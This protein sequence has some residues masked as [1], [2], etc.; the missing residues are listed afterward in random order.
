MLINTGPENS[1]V[2]GTTLDVDELELIY[3]ISSI[4]HGITMDKFSI[5]TSKNQIVIRSHNATLPH[6]FACA[7]FSISGQKLDVQKEEHRGDALLKNI[8]SGACIVQITL[9][10]RVFS[11]TV[12]VP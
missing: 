1:P 5:G 2:L 11:K 4:D 8:P 7:V 9:D 10:K 6:D 3:R 12:V